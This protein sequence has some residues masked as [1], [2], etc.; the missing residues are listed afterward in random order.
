VPVIAGR[1]QRLSEELPPLRL[2]TIRS[3]T[4]PSGTLPVDNRP[5]I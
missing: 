1:G 3:V 2:E 4:S 5:I